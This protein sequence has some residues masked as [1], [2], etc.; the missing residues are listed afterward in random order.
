MASFLA[1]FASV[2]FGSKSRPDWAPLLRNI[3]PLTLDEVDVFFC[4]V[5]KP[6]FEFLAAL[7][8]H[9]R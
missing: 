3:P 7:A 8:I 1:A 6:R 4:P 2:I 5:Q 9:E